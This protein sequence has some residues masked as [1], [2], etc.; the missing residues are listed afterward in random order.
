MYKR[1]INKIKIYCLKKNILKNNNYD[2]SKDIQI[3]GIP[4][5]RAVNGGK[6]K[7]GKNVKLNSDNIDYHINMH[8][9]VKLLADRDGAKIEIGENTR[10]HGSCIHSYA[11][12]SIGVNCLIAGNCQ[13]FDG[14]GHDLCLDNP[15]G[16]KNTS[17]GARPIDISDNVWIGG[18]S[19]I[20][21]GVSIGEGSVVAAG[22][23][24][25]KN[26]PSRSLVGGN[27]AKIIKQ[28]M[29]N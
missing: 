4:I 25:V 24:V 22:S 1:I 12:I 21:P 15:S 9:S 7:I 28:H 13:I 29:V 14:S 19:I 23:V 10:I 11:S 17:G 3:N 8:S 18:N 5:I 20:L 2:I 6:I 27:P 26:V 16:R